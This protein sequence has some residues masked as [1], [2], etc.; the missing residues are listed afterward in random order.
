MTDQ[1]A[2]Q[3]AFREG[4]ASS[5]VKALCTAWHELVNGSPETF[6]PKEPEPKLTE[7]LCEYLRSTQTD[8]KLTGDW[9]YEGRFAKL[10]RAA[11]GGLK[12]TN[13]TRTDIRYFSNR[14]DPPLKLTFEFK[15]LSHTKQRL[16]NYVGK[17]GMLRFITGD[18]GERQPLALM[19]G[20]LVVHRDD[21]MPVLLK[22][23]NG[24]KAKSEL[25]MTA[26]GI[27]AV[28]PS[29]FFPGHAEFDTQH[30]RSATNGGSADSVV[31]SHL[32][33]D[34][35]GLPL[36]PKKKAAGKKASASK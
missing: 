26:T 35:P 29:K 8:T 12:V 25:Q 23:M 22:Y 15:K 27:Q 36:A 3:R 13:R 14:E 4:D 34:F 2:W 11:S 30:A 24:S 17:E 10:S 5:V 18:Y 1:A 28:M 20:V 16:N 33:L 19:V 9:S 21:V 6:R 32:L 31:L 7:L